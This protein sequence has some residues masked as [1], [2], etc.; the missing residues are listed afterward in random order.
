MYDTNTPEKPPSLLKR[1]FCGLHSPL[2][3]LMDILVGSAKECYC[4]SFWRGALY[5]GIGGLLFALIVIF[6]MY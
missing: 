4:C 5:G 6:F 2:G 1:V 3:A